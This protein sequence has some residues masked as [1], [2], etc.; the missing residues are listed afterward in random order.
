MDVGIFY[1]LTYCT[2]GDTERKWRQ[3]RYALK[4]RGLIESVVHEEVP[5]SGLE[6][7]FIDLADP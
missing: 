5:P 1:S 3:I 4:N 6:E 2:T 7:E